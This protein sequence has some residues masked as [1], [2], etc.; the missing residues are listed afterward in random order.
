MTIEE[1]MAKNAANLLNIVTSAMSC[2]REDEPEDGPICWLCGNRYHYSVLCDVCN[3]PAC[4]SCGEK[5]DECDVCHKMIGKC[6]RATW[7]GTDYTLCVKC[8]EM[9]VENRLRRRQ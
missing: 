8:L 2:P 6:C 1:L 9:L 3:S 7:H 4:E 5:F